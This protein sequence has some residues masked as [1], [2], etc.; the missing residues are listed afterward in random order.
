MT[1]ALMTIEQAVERIE[2]KSRKAS[3]GVRVALAFGM[4][5]AGYGAIVV[6]ALRA[7]GAGAFA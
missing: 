3:R 2:A 6:E 4:I 7:G 1:Q 5:A